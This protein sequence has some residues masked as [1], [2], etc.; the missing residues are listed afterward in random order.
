MLRH[1]PARASPG[2][3]RPW[4]RRDA[5]GGV[6]AG[7]GRFLNPTGEALVLWPGSADYAHRTRAL[8]GSDALQSALQLC[9]LNLVAGLRRNVRRLV[10]NSQGGSNIGPR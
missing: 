5:Y 3:V 8:R 6:A 1:R 9:G 7:L 4:L 10:E 2:L